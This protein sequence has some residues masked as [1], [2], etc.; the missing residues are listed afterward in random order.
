MLEQSHF[1]LPIDYEANILQLF[2]S[3]KSNCLT[4]EVNYYLHISLTASTV[5]A[6]KCPASILM[7]FFG[8]FENIRPVTRMIFNIRLFISENIFKREQYFF[9]L[10][11]VPFP[12]LLQ[13][14]C[15]LLL[16]FWSRPWVKIVF[17]VKIFKVNLSD[18]VSH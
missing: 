15:G 18:T 8:A 17:N 12:V 3:C 11:C 14:V 4:S 10:K 2:E 13:N 7:S 16:F 9:Q 1:C 5:Y 6:L